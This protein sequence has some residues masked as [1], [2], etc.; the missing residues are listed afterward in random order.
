MVRVKNGELI[1][2]VGVSR[3]VSSSFGYSVMIKFKSPVEEGSRMKVQSS[4][5]LSPYDAG[6]RTSRST[7]SK[8]DRYIEG[9]TKVL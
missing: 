2:T 3:K 8:I 1:S 9:K 7:V 6:R 4:V 5:L